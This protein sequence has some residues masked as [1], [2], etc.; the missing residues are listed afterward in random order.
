M[1]TTSSRIMK[2][3]SRRVIPLA[4]LRYESLVETYLEEPINIFI[5]KNINDQMLIYE[6]IFRFKVEIANK[7]TMAYYIYSKDREN[8]SKEDL[9][10]RT[11]VWDRGLDILKVKK[12]K[13]KGENINEWPTI[14]ATTNLLLNSSLSRII[15]QLK[16]M[17]AILLKNGIKLQ[18]AN[19]AKSWKELE[20]YRLY[21]WGHIKVEWNHE[22]ENVALEEKLFSLAN[23]INN[24]IADKMAIQSVE[25]MELDFFMTPDNIHQAICGK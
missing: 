3:V 14:N 2:I 17:D 24:K 23:E 12:A 8:I 18:K 15:Q 13:E 16:E 4:L 6:N 10:V 11:F 19:S 22:K 25:K 20:V 21:D 5:T 9:V 1:E 7:Q